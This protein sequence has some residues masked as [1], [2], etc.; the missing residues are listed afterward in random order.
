MFKRAYERV[1]AITPGKRDVGTHKTPHEWE[2]Q[3]STCGLG[4]HTDEVAWLTVNT[5]TSG[6][7]YHVSVS[8]L[9]IS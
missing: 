2:L 6:W 3:H 7:G 9:Q 8:E 5:G 4:C 1:M